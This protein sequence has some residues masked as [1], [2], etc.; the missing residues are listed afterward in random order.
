MSFKFQ[1]TPQNEYCK[2]ACEKSPC[3]KLCLQE[4]ETKT[5][6]YCIET[7]DHPNAMPPNSNVPPNKYYC[8]C[9]TTEQD[10]QYYNYHY[11]RHRVV[12]R[13]LH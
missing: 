4:H 5:A 8:T 13:Y 11:H 12:G 10:S 2:E 3:G 9:M 1:Q 7:R 6:M